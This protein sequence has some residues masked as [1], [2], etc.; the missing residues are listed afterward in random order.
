MLIFATGGEGMKFL[1]YV[2]NWLINPIEKSTARAA[3][4]VL[5][6]GVN[7][8]L[9]LFPRY[10]GSNTSATILIAF[11]CVSYVVFIILIRLRLSSIG[12]AALDQIALSVPLATSG[13]ILAL[14]GG[15]PLLKTI[16]FVVV[17]VGLFYFICGIM[18]MFKYLKAKSGNNKIKP[19]ELLSCLTSIF[20]I[21]LIAANII[22]LFK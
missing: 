22:K 2:V 15:G 4:V 8:F 5:L 13:I 20:N 14:M 1:D 12:R 11:F 21:L 18:M 10:F 16:S 6:L 17:C 7:A 19:K 3:L 9:L